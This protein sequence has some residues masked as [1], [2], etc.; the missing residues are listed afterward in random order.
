MKGSH[1][2]RL[3]GLRAGVG[4]SRGRVAAIAGFSALLLAGA[5]A[6]AA[7]PDE[8]AAPSSVASVATVPPP[9]DHWLWV[10]DRL[11]HHSLLVDGDAGLVRG[12]LDTPTE[13]M[14]P[15]PLVSRSRGEIYSADILYSR[16]T[17]GTRSDFVSIYDWTTLAPKGEIEVPTRLGQSNTSLG[18]AELLGDRFI[19]LFNQ[20]PQ[21]SVSIL[22]IDGRRFVGEIPIAGCAAIYPITQSRFATLCGDGTALQVDLDADGKKQETRSSKSFFDPVGDPVF[23]AAG[24]DGARW[25]FV[26][27][28]GSVRTIDFS[29][30]TPRL[31]PEWSLLEAAGSS[32]DWRPGGLQHVAIHAGTRRLYVVMHEGGSG[33]HKQPGPEIW[34]FDLD[35]QERVARFEPPNLTVAWIASVA[36][37]DPESFTYRMM[38]WVMPPDGV[39]SIVV[40]PDERPVLF[41]RNAERGAV[42]VMDARSG[43]LLRVIGDAGLAGPTLGVP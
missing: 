19:A 36:G 21:V 16:G 11:L 42:A 24:R 12:I 35:S 13:L 17:R 18:Y 33:G 20:F 4:G 15:P 22:D 28:S 2:R 43:K 27:F 40:T 34:V 29:G 23:M 3:N 1:R 9:G 39:H 5:F 38:E 37:I 6:S 31:L 30:A 10:P 41:A 32:S 14:F 7:A 26:T 8:A 25:T